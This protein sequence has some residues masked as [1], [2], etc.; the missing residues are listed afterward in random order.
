MKSCGTDG[1]AFSVD[2]EFNVYFEYQYDANHALTRTI[3]RN[4][5][6][7]NAMW[8]DAD[9]GTASI[10]NYIVD[11]NGLVTENRYYGGPGLNG[12]WDNG[13]GDD[14]LQRLT[15]WT[16]DANKQ[17]SQVTTYGPGLDAKLG[18]PDDVITNYQQTTYDAFG[19]RIRA[20]AFDV[21]PDNAPYT[22]DDR[23]TLDTDYDTM[24]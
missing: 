5:P 6:G 9:D 10:E 23:L 11:P 12:V 20:R 22:G 2:D 14:D 13:S 19:N 21:G 8:L 17:A 4:N 7:L 3:E 1:L 24:H 15:K 16:Y 18:T